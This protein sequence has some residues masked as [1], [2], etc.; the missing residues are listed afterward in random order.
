MRWN[1]PRGGGWWCTC[2]HTVRSQPRVP[3]QWVVM[4]LRSWL[5][6][7]FPGC[8]FWWF[9]DPLPLVF[10]PWGWET[11]T[12]TYP[13]PQVCIGLPWR[14]PAHHPGLVL[15]SKLDAGVNRYMEAEGV[16][17]EGASECVAHTE[18]K[19]IKSSTLAKALHY[20]CTPA[21]SQQCLW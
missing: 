19:T 18:I 12:C 4:E 8:C 11:L 6:S 21:I 9:R 15:F 16:L 7:R 2:T 14:Q 13:S 20:H 1:H 3:I 5:S 10:Q 17:G